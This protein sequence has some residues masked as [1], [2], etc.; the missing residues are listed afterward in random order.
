MRGVLVPAGQ[1]R[2]MIPR[3]ELRRR[4]IAGRVIYAELQWPRNK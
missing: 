4:A 2:T 3:E 1:E